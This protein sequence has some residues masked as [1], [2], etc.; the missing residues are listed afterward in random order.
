MQEKILKKGYYFDTKIL[1]MFE[2]IFA[3]KWNSLGPHFWL[4]PRPLSLWVDM[5]HFT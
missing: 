1:S 3:W 4:H 2:M 5:G